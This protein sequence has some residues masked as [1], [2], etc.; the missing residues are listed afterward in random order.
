M[1]DRFVSWRFF[2][3]TLLPV[4]RDGAP[5]HATATSTLFVA[6]TWIFVVIAG[7][8]LATSLAYGILRRI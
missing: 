8:S 5:F 2:W 1:R 6:P 3:Y 7:L 4:A